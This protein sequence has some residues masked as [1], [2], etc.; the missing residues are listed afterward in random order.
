MIE[1]L[2]LY[3]KRLTCKHDYK[4]TMLNIF[5]DGHEEHVY[6]CK[7]CGHEKHVEL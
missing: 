1:R 7:K 2:K 3:W 5:P 4:R 6:V